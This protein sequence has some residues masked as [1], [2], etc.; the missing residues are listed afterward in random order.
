MS[1]TICEPIFG[2]L[3]SPDPQV[4]P[5]SHA[6]Q[7]F[8]AVQL[9]EATQVLIPSQR[10]L[11]LPPHRFGPQALAVTQIFQL[12]HPSPPV[13]Q[14]FDVWQRFCCSQKLELVH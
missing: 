1:P 12:A 8:P 14:L 11:E 13:R 10:F 9:F 3:S 6:P 2:G 4:L 7:K 5:E